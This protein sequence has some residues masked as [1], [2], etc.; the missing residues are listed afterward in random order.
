MKSIYHGAM[1]TFEMRSEFILNIEQQS[2]LIFKKRKHMY[3]C[4]LKDSQPL[5]RMSL[6]DLEVFLEWMW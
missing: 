1:I 5:Y 4:I 6:K 3:R 2:E